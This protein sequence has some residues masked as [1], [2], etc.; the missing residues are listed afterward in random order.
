MIAGKPQVVAQP[1]RRCWLP[2]FKT[3]T[4]MVVAKPKYPNRRCWLRS[5]TPTQVRCWLPNPALRPEKEMVLVEPRTPAGDGGGETL[6]DP[7]RSSPK[8]QLRLRP[9]SFAVCCDGGD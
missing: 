6:E 8:P 3:N 2:N 1:K 4:E 9:L 5:R 7:K